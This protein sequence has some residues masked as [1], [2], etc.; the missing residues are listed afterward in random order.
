MSPRQKLPDFSVGEK[1][2][3]VLYLL[4]YLALKLVESQH[5]AANSRILLIGVFPAESSQQS[6]LVL[7][8]W[9]E[10]HLLHLLPVC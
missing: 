8:A 5:E 3:F 4:Q 1:L 6:C 10:G 9:Q 2:E 7:T